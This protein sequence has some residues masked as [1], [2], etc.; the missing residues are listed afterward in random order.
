[1]DNGKKVGILV[2]GVAVLVGIAYLTSKL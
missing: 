2:G 1:L